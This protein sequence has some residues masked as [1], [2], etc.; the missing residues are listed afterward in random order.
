MALVFSL[1]SATAFACP[2]GT[3]LVGGTGE[4]HKGGK[5][6]AADD[7][8][9]EKATDA[10]PNAKAENKVAAKEDAKADNKAKKKHDKS[11]DKQKAEESK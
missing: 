9:P 8:S 1:A 2:K 6:V 4:H 3:H 7:K 10:K 5:C 11:K